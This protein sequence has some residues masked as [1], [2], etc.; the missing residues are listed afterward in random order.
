MKRLA[1]VGLLVVAVAVTGSVAWG[2]IGDSGTVK[3][4]FAKKR[5][6][7]IDASASCK[8]KEGTIDL[9]T[10]SGADA[11]FLEARQLLSSGFVS[12]SPGQ[13]TTLADTG[14]IKVVGV[15]T[16]G[17]TTAVAIEEHDGVGAFG[18]YTSDTVSMPHQSGAVNDGASATIAS[19]TAG[20]DGGTYY[21]ASP[22]DANRAVSGSFW[23]Y[24]GA[25]NTCNFEATATV[26]NSTTNTSGAASRSAPT[27][28]TPL[29][30]PTG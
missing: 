11:A 12:L 22:A 28:P 6:W 30:V 4:C 10:K 8:P 15:C 3:S 17:P 9:Y 25:G 2:A 26:N 20:V 18:I 7:L 27:A 5:W 14:A 24:S 23:G 29:P 1:V 16:A 19:S 13:T 21:V